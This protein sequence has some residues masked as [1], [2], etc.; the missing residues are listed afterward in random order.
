MPSACLP[1]VAAPDRADLQAFERLALRFAAML[2]CERW[3]EA[4]RIG[5]ASV[6]A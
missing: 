2:F 5:A 6:L 1:R 4:A 3:E